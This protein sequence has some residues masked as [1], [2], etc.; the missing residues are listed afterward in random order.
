MSKS[1]EKTSLN[2]S[3]KR[4]MAPGKAMGKTSMGIPPFTQKVKHLEKLS[5]IATTCKGKIK[6]T[7]KY[8]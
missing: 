1:S 6:G 7:D 8:S 4:S 5:A 2:F 3:N